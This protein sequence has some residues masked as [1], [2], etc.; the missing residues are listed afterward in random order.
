MATQAGLAAARRLGGPFEHMSAHSLPVAAAVAAPVLAWSAISHGAL[1]LAGAGFAVLA[2]LIAAKPAYT[3]P[4]VVA[5]A[6]L[7]A[8]VRHGETAALA[9]ALLIICVLVLRLATG[10]LRPRARQLA[11]AP[12]ACALLLSYAAPAAVLVPQTSRYADL[13]G[14]LEG[15]VLLTLVVCA[16]P[17][18]RML[19]SL[20]GISGAVL[21]IYALF[22]G[23]RASGRLEGLGLNPNYLG[24]LVAVP[25]V[26]SLGLARASRSRLWAV[27]AAFC[28][29]ALAATQSRGAFVAAAAG[30]TVLVVSGRTAQMK[31][32]FAAA[33]LLAAA[34]LPGSLST[35]ENS[36]GGERAPAELAYDDGVRTH[37]ASFALDVAFSHPL[38]GIGYDMFAPYAADSPE[39]GIYINTHD[40]Y[41][42]LAA[43][44]GVPGLALMLV[45]LVPAFRVQRTPSASTLRAGVLA[46]AAGLL[47]TNTLA[48][49]AVS[50][51]FW[52]AL[53]V[54]HASTVPERAVTSP[55]QPPEPR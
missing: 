33:A 25:L 8:T 51:P 15:L 16:P 45:L 39:V 22:V 4:A 13:A 47:F 37:V 31:A 18:E 5:I 41:L 20:I 55:L 52:A 26:V 50:A 29:A 3:A 42:R 17:A 46:Y 24:L 2:Y 35:L 19:A 9:A 14:L 32:G 38:R 12:L 44:T 34:L 11:A 23:D 54:L 27:P 43:E 48:N 30:V 28:F 10:S 53:G 21:S 49:L 40:D 1:L 6:P 7:Q 36:G